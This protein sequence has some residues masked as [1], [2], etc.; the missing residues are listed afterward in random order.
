MLPAASAVI[1]KGFSI[2]A[3]V[4]GPPSPD[5][6][7]VPSP[8]NVEIMPDELI[9]LTLALFVKY[10]LPPDTTMPLVAFICAAVSGPPSPLYP[11][12]PVPAIVVMMPDGSIL[13]IR[14]LPS[15]A[16]YTPDASTAIAVG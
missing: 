14:W 6:A 10:T 9:T 7:M 3:A 11:E 8:A 4:A 5:V 2:C 12:V 15:S 1:P 13:R 16:I